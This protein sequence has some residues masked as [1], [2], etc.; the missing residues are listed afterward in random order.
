VRDQNLQV[1]FSLNIRSLDDSDELLT[2]LKIF[3]I[4]CKQYL[5]IIF[6]S[7]MSSS[8]LKEIRSRSKIRLLSQYFF[9]NSEY[10]GH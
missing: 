9:L 7:N 1:I 5:F 4:F 6:E 2:F 8:T 10:A 3:D